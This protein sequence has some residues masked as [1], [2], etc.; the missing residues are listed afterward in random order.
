MRRPAST[1]RI[2]PP[3]TLP[4]IG[5]QE[6][7]GYLAHNV[8]VALRYFP[9]G[10]QCPP[11]EEFVAAREKEGAALGNILKVHGMGHPNLG[12]WLSRIPNETLIVWGEK[13]RMVPARQAPS[14][15]RADP[16]SPRSH[17]SRR[18]PFR[19]AGRPADRESHRRFPRRVTCN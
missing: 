3:P 8:D 6:L 19:H 16:E 12:R 13:D 15:G 2:I 7:P 9:G 5:P 17:R 1:T 11:P 4:K 18:R 10:S 14:L